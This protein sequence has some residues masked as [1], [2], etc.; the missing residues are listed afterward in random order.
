MNF[1]FKNMMSKAMNNKIKGEYVSVKNLTQVITGKED[2]NFS[3]ENGKY[4]FFTCSNEALKCNE[5]KF[6]SSS[7][8]IAGN[9]DFNVKHYTGKFNAYQRTYVLTPQ[10]DYYALLYLSSVERINA[11]KLRS[12][13]SIIK[14]ITKNDIESIPVFI[15]WD[16]N[17]L[18]IL[19]QLLSLKDKK[20]NENEYLA[21]LRDYLLPLL[22]N[23]QVTIED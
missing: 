17:I 22:L 18:N 7:I 9:G 16:K 10:K 1:I 21:S 8:L 11:L 4:K 3:D 23:G 19:N 12:T 13:G 2:A 14:F 6:N 5:Y 15:P 20:S